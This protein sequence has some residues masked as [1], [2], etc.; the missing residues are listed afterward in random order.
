LCDQDE[1]SID[2]IIVYLSFTRDLRL[3]VL[4]ALGNLL[5]AATDR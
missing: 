5:L 2:H 1:E 4:V 3:Y